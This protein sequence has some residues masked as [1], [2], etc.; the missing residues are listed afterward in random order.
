M[1]NELYAAGY[2]EFMRRCDAAAKGDHA[3]WVSLLRE[4][5]PRVF[6]QPM[7]VGREEKILRKFLRTC[8]HLASPKRSKEG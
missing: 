3:A 7:P 1:K 5:M 4:T 8:Q 2:D 6:S